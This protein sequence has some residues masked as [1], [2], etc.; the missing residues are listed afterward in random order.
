MSSYS[1]SQ[2][3]L[4]EIGTHVLEEQNATKT[5]KN[6]CSRS[7][8]NCLSLEATQMSANDKFINK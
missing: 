3:L 4:V 1:H 8:Y 7:M 5:H 2:V 6:V